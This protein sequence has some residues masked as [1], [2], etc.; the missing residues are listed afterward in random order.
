VLPQ[1]FGIAS[2]PVAQLLDWVKADLGAST[3]AVRNACVQ[4]VGVMHSFLG[5]QVSD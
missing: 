5:P 3:P 2:L 1:E 4:L